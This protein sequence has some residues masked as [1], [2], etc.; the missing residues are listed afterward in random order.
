MSFSR[1]LWTVALLLLGLPCVRGQRAAAPA[2]A[3]VTLA[4]LQAI[5]Q[6]ADGTQRA[7]A[8]Q[9]TLQQW[10]L[11]L[12]DGYLHQFDGTA[13]GDSGL[14]VLGDRMLLTRQLLPPSGAGT[15]AVLITVPPMGVR[16][17]N[18]YTNTSM[19]PQKE[20][21]GD[22]RFPRDAIGAYWNP[23]AGAGDLSTAWHEL[24]HGAM[25]GHTLSVRAADWAPY[26]YMGGDTDEH[27]VY[28]E[29]LTGRTV[30][31]LTALLKTQSFEDRIRK[32]FATLQ[33]YRARK[34][35]IDFFR[36]RAIWAEAHGAW[37]QAF[38]LARKIAPLP[39]AQRQEYA[40]LTG[41]RLP[42]VEE[43]VN[44]YL[45]GRMRDRRTPIPV[46]RW[47]MCA[48]DPSMDVIIQDDKHVPAASL[49]AAGAHTFNLLVRESFRSRAPMTQGM[50]DF[51]LTPAD[52][53]VSLTVSLGGKA[54][55]VSAATPALAR[56]STTVNLATIAE[57]LKKS[58]NFT[59]Q[60]KHANPAAVVGKKT[61]TIRVAYLGF[62]DGQNRVYNSTEALFFIDIQGKPASPKTTA[63][64]GKTA[65]PKT[66]CWVLSETKRFDTNAGRPRVTEA[67]FGDGN[68]SA[69]VQFGDKLVTQKATWTV[70]P[71]T[72]K[73]AS[74]IK[75]FLSSV[76]GSANVMYTGAGL[77]WK[78]MT[79]PQA[80]IGSIDGA[81][82]R[83]F[84]FAIPYGESAQDWVNLTITCGAMAPGADAMIAR[85]FVYK[86]MP[87][88]AAAPTPTVPFAASSTVT[89]KALPAPACPASLTND[90][91][92]PGDLVPTK[93]LPRAK[94][95][96]PRKKPPVTR[97]IP[98]KQKKIGTYLHPDKSLRLKL[99]T[100]WGVAVGYPQPALD[101]LA[102]AS[103][104]LVL[105]VDRAAYTIGTQ[106]PEQA[107][108]ATLADFKRQLPNGAPCAFEVGT[109]GTDTASGLAS[110]HPG[111]KRMQWMLAVRHRT[112]L[113]LLHVVL[114]P[115][116]GRQ[117]FP[118][119]VAAM[120]KTVE[121]LEPTH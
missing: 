32:A 9:A 47:V 6:H 15:V 39:D 26:L 18:W 3:P 72:L 96:S 92:Q 99:P 85:Q 112:T 40:G 73:P 48:D 87:A 66:M 57:R 83:E 100:G 31:W 58:N 45:S 70:P 25:E 80:Q 101:C 16:L 24:N 41:A 13:L 10:L 21:H 29:G 1:I 28:I 116:S 95:T 17:V 104:P 97:V 30:D 75:F 120:L 105:L 42:R 54:L 121:Y 43:V 44:F 51:S 38:P 7:G 59:V 69:T 22:L 5:A 106:T 61:Y 93:P 37:V 56:T 108:A 64:S 36:E 90:P 74:T 91:A 81:G 53:E 88:P 14:L 110:Y 79:Q 71:S 84:S 82:A 50:L 2:P 35:E 103:Y 33:A 119:G 89:R 60:F 34:E 49:D 19:S 12:T 107:A 98:P 114:P 68:F 78:G 76:E 65:P 11:W 77:S 8:D 113:Y 20:D 62:K 111:L 55:P 52:P 109:T 67:A 46:P 118:A 27:H 23:Y 94:S 4:E 86:W 63:G 117:I 115:G 102:P